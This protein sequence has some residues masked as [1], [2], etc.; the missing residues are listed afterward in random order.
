MTIKEFEIQYALGSLSEYT[1]DQLA[2]D[3]DTSKGILII[4]STDKNY[5]IRYRVAGNFNTPKEVL[6]KL[7]VDKDWYVKWRAI[8]HMSGDLNK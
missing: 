1:K 4:L 2:Y 8:R 7:S 3:S 6:T 5:S